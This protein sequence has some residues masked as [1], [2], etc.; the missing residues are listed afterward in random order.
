MKN[1]SNPKAQ[2]EQL[3]LHNP[4]SLSLNTP[5]ARL[6]RSVSGGERK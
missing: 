2:A 5:K 1:E 3:P 4:T 6:S